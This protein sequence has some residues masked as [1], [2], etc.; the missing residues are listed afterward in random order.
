MYCP[1][2]QAFK[3]LHRS[4][5]RV[6]LNLLETN[7][8]QSELVYHEVTT[9]SV[10]LDAIVSRH[11]T[12]SNRLGDLATASHN[13]AAAGPTTVHASASEIG[14]LESALPFTSAST[15]P[16]SH[17]GSC[18]PAQDIPAASSSDERPL[19]CPYSTAGNTSNYIPGNDGPHSPD[20]GIVPAH[21]PPDDRVPHGPLY[22]PS[23]TGPSTLPDPSFS[24]DQPHYSTVGSLSTCSAPQ[25]LPSRD[26][27]SQSP[28]S[29]DPPQVGK[30][31]VSILYEIQDGVLQLSPTIEQWREFPALLQCARDLGVED[32]G[33]CKV[34]LPESVAGMS[35]PLRHT[36]R[37]GFRYAASPQSNG[38]FGLERIEQDTMPLVRSELTDVPS[39][40]MPVQRFE[41]LLR[42]KSGLNGVRYCT[43]ID[44]RT[45][46]ARGSLGLS[47]SPIWPLKGDRL[48]ETRMRIPGLHW[49]YAYEAGET[50]GASFAMHRE[51]GDLLSI[52]YLYEGDKYWIVIPGNQA[53]SLEGKSIQTNKSRYMSHC[54][55][56]LRHSATY[57]P[58]SILDDWGISYKIIHQKG[59]EVV[60]TF[61]QVYH[62]GFSAGYTFAEAINYADQNW[63]IQGYHECGSPD[64]SDGSIKNTMLE[65]RGQDEV[66]YSERDGDDDRHASNL[67]EKK[68]SQARRHDHSTAKKREASRRKPEQKPTAV[69]KK[70]DSSG[71]RAKRKSAIQMSKEA[72]TKVS[73]KHKSLT[74]S[75]LA[76][77]KELTP[78]PKNLKQPA[79]V[80]HIFV[81]RSQNEDHNAIWFLTRLFFAIASPDAFY[82]LRDACTA[83]RQDGELITAR[84]TNSVCQT[85]QTLD[86]LDVSMS[87][88]SILRRYHL[89]FLVSC[90]NERE[91]HHQSQGRERVPRTLKYGYESSTHT[92]RTVLRGDG[93]SRASS[94]AL[95]DMMAEAYPDLKSGGKRGTEPDTVYPKK[96]RSLKER[97]YSGKN[98][99]EMQQRLS[100]GILAL[101]PT[102]GDYNIQNSEY[103]FLTD[104][105]RLILTQNRVERLP[106]YLIALFLDVLVEFRGDFLHEVSELVSQHIRKILYREDLSQKYVF[107]NLDGTDLKQEPLDSVKF[108]DFCKSHA[109][110]I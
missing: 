22:V 61:P 99:Y 70:Q 20:T 105:S 109:S 31:G 19:I 106:E 24:Q 90:R 108:I 50:F 21:L 65:F 43:D 54:A 47:K 73:K 94:M 4:I 11:R 95:A 3:D 25:S 53:N 74:N 49:P 92:R 110:I 83:S 37:K 2:S 42:N 27:P 58:T 100:P 71:G 17:G 32:V 80:F 89:A 63:N 78:I 34:I 36:K 96:Y 33:I 16:T 15:H 35:K 7:P 62:Q 79:D 46:K 76:L 52:N 40:M 93:Y 14:P 13:H 86:Q 38:T 84:S 103:D 44:V 88:A 59:G 10:E 45:P 8:Q 69:P 28:L 104:I 51:D 48:S 98:W 6:I 67:T 41:H 23:T 68:N 64:C 29:Q 30:P 107:E 91:A 18:I 55:Q 72:P 60:V 1:I 77:F 12:K 97:V 26:R 57:Y 87:T 56:F 75:G 102:R 5:Q 82:Q 81:E 85:V 9:L 101:V 66:Q 39:G